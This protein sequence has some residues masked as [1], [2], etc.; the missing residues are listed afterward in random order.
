MREQLLARL[1]GP[2]DG[3]PPDAFAADGSGLADLLDQAARC[4]RDQRLVIAVDALDEADLA[5]QERGSNVLYLPPHLPDGVFFLLTKRDVAMP[6]VADVPAHTID[7][8]APR[9]QAANLADAR[10]YLEHAASLPAV[11][12]WLGQRGVREG[13]FISEVQR[14]SAANFM[15]LHHVVQDIQAGRFDGRGLATLPEGLQGYYQDH[16]HLMGMDASPLPLVKLRVLYVLLEY[17]E[18]VTVRVLAAI[19][20]E[21]PSA[22]ATVIREWRQFLRTDDSGREKGYSL[23]HESFADFLREDEV[24]AASRVDLAEINGLIADHLYTSE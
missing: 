3:P 10:A 23:Y 22:V 14:R 11:I 16:W 18:P 2:R 6:L 5:T 15:Y 9:F 4:S 7:L 19:V 24:L 21:S 13:S 1:G 17:Q 12:R 20:G 8:M